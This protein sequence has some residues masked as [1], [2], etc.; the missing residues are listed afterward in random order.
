ME[1]VETTIS[2]HIYNQGKAEGILEGQLAT[3]EILYQQGILS[4]EQ[5][6]SMSAPLRQKLNEL[7]RARD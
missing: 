4:A 2:E 3:L 6:N 7:V 1:L 5:M